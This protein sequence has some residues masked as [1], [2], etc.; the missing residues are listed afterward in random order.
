MVALGQPA[1]R[2]GIYS[3]RHPERRRYPDNARAERVV[4]FGIDTQWHAWEGPSNLANAPRYHQEAFVPAPGAQAI[5]HL[6]L[7]AITESEQADFR[8]MAESAAF[9]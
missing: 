2:L 4:L 7:E 6:F 8:R 1:G 3:G 5:R 9:K